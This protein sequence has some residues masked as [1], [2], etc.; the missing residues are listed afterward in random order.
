MSLWKKKVAILLF[1]HDK[2]VKVVFSI[3]EFFSIVLPI[4]NILQP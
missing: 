2:L 3:P 4:W 1:R